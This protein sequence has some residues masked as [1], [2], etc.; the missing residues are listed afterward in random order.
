[1][2]FDGNHVPMAGLPLGFALSNSGYPRGIFIPKPGSQ[3]SMYLAFVNR[4]TTAPPHMRR[5]GL[6]AMDVG[7]PGAPAGGTQQFITWIATDIASDF[8]VVPHANESDYWIMVQP[9]GGNAFHAYLVSANGVSGVPVV[10]NAGPTRGVDWQDG[11][12]ALNTEGT[13]FACATRKSGSA[14]PGQ[15]DTLLTELFAFDN[16]LGVAAHVLTLPSKRP[17]GMEFSASGRFLFVLEQMPNGFLSPGTPGTEVKLVQYDMEADLIAESREVVHEYVH[18]TFSNLSPCVQLLRGID[19]RI[20][21]KHEGESGFLGVVMNPELPAALCGYLHDGLA[22]PDSVGEG[23]GFFPPMK[24]YH[25]SPAIITSVPEHALAEMQVAPQ[26][27]TEA[28]WLSH[29]S[30]EGSLQIR[31]HDAA[32]RIARE[33]PV[34]ASAGRARIEAD[35]LAQ[36]LYTVMVSGGQLAAPVSGRVVVGR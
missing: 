16:D 3:D 8:V 2:V 32:G 9:I 27:L 4:Y 19:G 15:A 36:G 33:D 13:M 30:L 6:L 26:P 7:L 25:D 18:P 11:A 34:L 10:S 21:C 35:G 23:F 24:R 28:G 17:Q 31:W 22:V 14:V 1:M 29:P 5:I 20:Y 12:W